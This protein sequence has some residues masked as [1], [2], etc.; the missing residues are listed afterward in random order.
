VE[1]PK[2]VVEGLKMAPKIEDSKSIKIVSNWKNAK[3]IQLE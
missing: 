3:M 2:I 1:I